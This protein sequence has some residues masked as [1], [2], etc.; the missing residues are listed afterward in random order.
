MIRSRIICAAAAGL[1]LA[2]CA[3]TSVTGVDRLASARP[4]LVSYELSA[5]TS[6]NGVTPS[7][8]AGN[9]RCSA[10]IPG[11][12]EIKIDVSSVE[13]GKSYSGGFTITKLYY[14]GVESIGIDFT[15]TT[16]V[17]GVLMKGSNGA[18]LYD[19]RTAGSTGD[20][21]LYTPENASNTNAGI[22]HITICY[23]GDGP[24]P[25]PP[26]SLLQVLKFYDADLDGVK[27][28]AEP[29]LE[30]WKIGL[31][32]SGGSQIIDV[33]SYAA[34]QAPG[35][36][37][38]VEFMP[39]ESNW[40]ATT[41]TLFLVNHTLAGST[42]EFGNVCTLTPTGGRT[43]GFQSNKNGQALQTADMFTALTNLNLVNANGSARDF[44]ATLD[45][46]KTALRNWL[47]AGESTNMAYMLSVQLAALK[48]TVMQGTLSGG[49]VI[50]PD[51][52]S[53]DQIIAAADALLAADGS[54]PSGDPNRAAQEQIKNLIDNINNNA[55]QVVSSTPCTY[56]FPTD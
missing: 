23:G 27:D 6:T 12:R 28:D 22:S 5:Y 46:N 55:V 25:P 39:I 36:F 4:N 11:S 51:G 43:L 44:T 47:L 17:A 34:I 38:I 9:P 14:K 8:V 40:H 52:R 16:P 50:Y 56:T 10:V 20:G 26:Q 13:E 45:K 37:T 19:Y 2:A 35:Q 30:N 24:P 21:G 33:T 15:S 31:T 42:T 18:H 29:Y 53:I 49:S 41:P 7:F 3:D 48:L 32:R 1:L 54:T